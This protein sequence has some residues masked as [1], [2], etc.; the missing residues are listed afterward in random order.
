MTQNLSIK[1]DVRSHHTW[2]PTQLIKECYLENVKVIPNEEEN[3]IIIQVNKLANANIK[4]KSS[5]LLF[6]QV[7]SI[8]TFTSEKLVIFFQFEF[9]SVDITSKGME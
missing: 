3:T 4:L 8:L 6:L 7:N 2:P 9:H 5:L 1:I